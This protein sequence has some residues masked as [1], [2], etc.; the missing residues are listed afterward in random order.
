[1]TVSI[2]FSSIIVFLLVWA[3]LAGMILFN[4]LLSRSG[5]P[6]MTRMGFI[7]LLAFL[8]APTIAP[9]QVAGMTDAGYLMAL[10]R[11][12]FVGFVYGFAFQ[13][14][15]YFLFFAGDLMDNDIGLAMARTFD[16]GTNIQS[17]FSGR[18]VSLIFAIY[19][20]ASGAH[21]AIIKL[22]VDSFA[23]IPLGAGGLTLDVGRFI[24]K[25]FT[26][27]FMLVI[28]LVAPITV[29]EFVLQF[30]MGVLMKFIPQITVF[31]I[32]FQLRILLGLIL[33]FLM[34][35]FIG[36]FIDNYI[37]VLLTNLTDLPMVI[38]GS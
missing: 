37:G 33:L 25:L 11:E 30:G 26:S 9:E 20:F 15:Y 31:V 32:N 3:R 16:P 36:N 21:Y 28:R 17:A 6:M 10:F 12:V 7:F 19:I 14:F 22:Y 5:V 13:I 35:P 4:P 8:V 29:A 23:M 18:M 34:A 27:V 24:L 1:M 38:N 2:G